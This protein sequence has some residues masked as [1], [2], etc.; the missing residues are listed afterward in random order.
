[1]FAAIEGES[2]DM[3]ALAEM[4]HAPIVR[5]RPAA[6]EPLARDLSLFEMLTTGAARNMLLALSKEAYEA[7]YRRV[8][9]LNLVYHGVSDP[10]GI[11]HVFLDNAANYRKPRIFD[12]IFK[13]AIGE[14]LFTADGDAWRVQRRLMAPAF[15]PSAVS[16]FAPLF[17]GAAAQAAR[18]LP[19]AIEA[20]GG[21]VDMA[22][23]TTRATLSVID[24]ALFSGESGMPFDET[25]EMVRAFTGGSTELTLG[26][27]L[28]ATFLDQNPRQRL[29]RRARRVLVS[30]MSAFLHRRADA[31]E[32]ADDFVARLYRAFLAAHPRDD[33]I[34]MTLDNALTFFV[35]G[36]ETTANGLAW[37][38]Y[39]LAGDPRAQAWAREEARA[40]WTE[41]DDPGDLIGR[42]PYLKMVWEETLRLYPP[43]YR[44][45]REALADDEVCGQPV[46]KGDQI[47]VWPWL[48]HRHRRLWQE[49]DLFN[50]ENFDPE[51][52]A[53]RPR[54]Q[55]IP[56]GAGPRMC[57]GMGFAEAEALILL[58]RWIAEHRFRP[59]PSHT[60][61]PKADVTLR[62]E[63]GLP[64]IVERAPT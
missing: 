20:G 51:A 21:V 61:Q 57:I 7:P 36:H 35:A 58:S 34:Q 42:M 14:G 54:F 50:P 17:A 37:A 6:P 22:Q 24:Q 43:V 59:V 4:L 18:R 40:A 52:K 23:E 9:A 29:A 33:A 39:L 10:A 15:L 45:D 49:P 32:Q 28:G 31:P 16:A 11:Q 26:L 3:T 55:Y 25:T 64:L 48:V 62:P 47:T 5:F 30:K 38:L 41:S 8:R 27:L 53:G 2:A 1:M 44:I 46:R 56:F 19:A 63:G 12:R 60:V 13:P